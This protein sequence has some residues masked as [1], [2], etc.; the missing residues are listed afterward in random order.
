MS[1]GKSEKVTYKPYEQ[2][3]PYLIPPSADELIPGD[4]LVRLA[5]EAI[6]QMGI[7]PLLR[8]YQTGE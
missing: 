3:Q 4:H 5:S 1:K 7:E 6:D 8:K 2:N